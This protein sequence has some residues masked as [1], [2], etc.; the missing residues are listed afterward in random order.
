MLLCDTG[1]TVV[2]N[3]NNFNGGSAIQ[4]LLP[5]RLFTMMVRRTHRNR[6]DFQSAR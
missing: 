6:I 3:S 4:V 5:L 2:G 1:D